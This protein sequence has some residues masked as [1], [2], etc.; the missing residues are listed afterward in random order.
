[1]YRLACK[2]PG[3]RVGL[4][5]AVVRAIPASART[6]APTTR[7]L[8]QLY[9]KA[10]ALPG[11]KKVLVASGVRYDLAATSKEYV[12]ELA[13]HHVG[14]YL[15]IAPEHTEEGPLSKMLKPG[16]GSY[17]KFKQLFNE[18]SEKAGK[19]QYLI[20]YFIAS[21]PGTTDRD[22]LA[23][24]LWLKRNDFR[25]DQV[26]NF[27]PSPMAT[28][29]RDVPHRAQPAEA[30]CG[31]TARQ[32]FVPKAPA[33]A[34]AAQGV[35]ALPRSGELAAAAAGAAQD[36]AGRS[37]RQRPEQAD[38]DCTSRRRRA[39]KPAAAR[40]G[41]RPFRTHTHASRSRCEAGVREPERVATGAGVG[42][43]VRA[44]RE[45]DRPAGQLGHD[46]AASSVSA[47]TSCSMRAISLRASAS[48][49][50]GRS[51]SRRRSS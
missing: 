47:A 14:G 42:A 18:A 12:R 1:M 5:A 28:R 48:A 26:Q 37:D 34:P 31:A 51:A 49:P 8:I 7:S 10:R 39:A 3:D 19:K 29:D 27:L 2:E 50:G 21:H 45:A 20:P 23:L 11:V 16:I 4:P 15:K 22:M 41:G 25:A 46:H 40:K 33:D 17:E 32:V 30:S 13:T 35:P 43:R 44:Q 38:P 6:C 24:A 36:G 9:R